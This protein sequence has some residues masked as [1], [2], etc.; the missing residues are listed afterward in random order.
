[1]QTTHARG[2]EGLSIEL[3]FVPSWDASEWSADVHPSRPSTDEPLN[4][5]SETQQATLKAEIHIQNT[6]SRYQANHKRH[7]NFPI[8]LTLHVLVLV[9]CINIFA[10]EPNLHISQMTSLACKLL[11]DIIN[12]HNLQTLHANIYENKFH[13][14]YSG[15]YFGNLYYTSA[16]D[17]S[18]R[19]KQK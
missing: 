5:T 16:S 13:H 8:N 17:S 10:L 3:T 6:H 4:V 2:N 7:A 18:P 19:K 1:M 9:I 11:D 14:Y 12:M 15:A